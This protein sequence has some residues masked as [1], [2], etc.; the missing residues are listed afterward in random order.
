MSG[1]VGDDELAA[2]RAE[3]AVGDVN[4]DPLLALGAQ[5]VGQQREVGTVRRAVHPAAAHLFEMILPNR[6]AVVEQATDQ[7]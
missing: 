7:G 4:R 5:A 1:C 6:L 2:R 3:I